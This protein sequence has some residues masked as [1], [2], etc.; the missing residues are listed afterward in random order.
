[1]RFLTAILL[2]S[3]ARAGTI[4]SAS[5]TFPG[6]LGCPFGDVSGSMTGTDSASFNAVCDSHFG[7]S[8]VGAASAQAAIG[9]LSASSSVGGRSFAPQAAAA[10]QYTDTATLSGSTV[11]FQFKIDGTLIRDGGFA[12]G[13][14]TISV[15]GAS[16][17]IS[18]APGGHFLKLDQIY[19]SVPLPVTPGVPFT[20]TAELET[21][22]NLFGGQ[23]SA[24]IQAIL[25][26]INSS[27][28]TGQEVPEPG[29]LSLVGAGCMAALAF[30]RIRRAVMR[31]RQPG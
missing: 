23:A 29:T 27:G 17:S 28:E 4:T 12:S 19:T 22:A 7:S 26:A 2:I 5:V 25:A 14:F 6:P 30:A 31:A 21:S 24:D 1:M 15:P 9:Q 16:D 13:L 18:F 20:Y 8:A 11:V 10:A 3:A